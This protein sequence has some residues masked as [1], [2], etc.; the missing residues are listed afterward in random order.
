MASAESKPVPT[1]A[2]SSG[3]SLQRNELKQLTRRSDRPGLIWLGAWLGLLLGSGWL[4]YI[5]DGTPWYWPM[6]IIYG[7]FIALPAYALSHECAH[8]TAFRS[9]WLNEILFWISSIL[10]FEEPVY[11]RYAHARHHTYTWINGLDF[12]QLNVDLIAGM[13]G[14]SGTLSNRAITALSAT[15]CASV[16]ACW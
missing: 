9:R 12:D 7:S 10:F 5:A 14:I 2:A 3:V 1:N 13:P 8:G 6:L 11:R 15:T 16:G 4:V